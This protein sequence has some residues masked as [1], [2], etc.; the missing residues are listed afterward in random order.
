MGKGK[1]IL[2]KAVQLINSN[3]ISNERL[4]GWIAI[5]QFE[6]KEEEAFHLI[7]TGE[8]VKFVDVAHENP[9]LT[10]KSDTE[11]ISRIYGGEEDIMEAIMSKKLIVDGKLVDGQKFQSIILPA[12]EG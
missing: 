11:T 3:K 7:F 1:E 9:T 10:L 5:V 8:D 6:L 4:S 12:F 2:Q